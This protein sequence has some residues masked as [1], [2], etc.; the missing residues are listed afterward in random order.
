MRDLFKNVYLSSMFACHVYE[1]M[2]KETKE[3]KVISCEAEREKKKL[4]PI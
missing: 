4:Q 3:E 2:R 1:K